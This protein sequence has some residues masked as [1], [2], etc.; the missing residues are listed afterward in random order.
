[1]TS[2]KIRVG[3]EFVHVASV[4]TPAVYNV[5]VLDTPRVNL[6]QESWLNDAGMDVEQF[7]DLYANRGVRVM[8]PNGESLSKYDALVE[9]PDELDEADSGAMQ[10]APEDIPGEYLVYTLPSRYCPS[11]VMRRHAWKLFG[12]K[13]AN[14]DRVQ[15]ICDYVNGH[16]TFQYGSS[17]ATSTALDVYVSGYG[18]CRDFTHLGVTLMRALNIPTRYVFGYLPDMDV[19]PDPAPMDFAAWLEVYLDGRWFT[20]DPRNNAR[21]KGR[22]LISRGRDAADVAMA[23]TFGAPWLKRMTVFADEVAS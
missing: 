16:L 20:F 6:L 3:C 12:N 19:P 10:C 22:V 4:P 1:M 9:V 17:E 5:Q 7:T 23:T 11:D 2:R 13:P 8:L 18:V 15:D 14:Y 21:R